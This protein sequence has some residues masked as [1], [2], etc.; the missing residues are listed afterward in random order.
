MNLSDY[1]Y[2]VGYGIG[3]YYDYIKKSLNMF[4]ENLDYSPMMTSLSIKI[5]KSSIP[6]RG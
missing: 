1:K 3:Q 2:V 6:Y 5:Q 4:I